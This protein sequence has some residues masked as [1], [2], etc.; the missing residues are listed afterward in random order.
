MVEESDT[1]TLLS[2]NLHRA[3]CWIP[4]QELLMGLAAFMIELWGE[5]GLRPLKNESNAKSLR[6][7]DKTHCNLVMRNMALKALE[8]QLMHRI[9]G[10][11]KNESVDPTNRHAFDTFDAE[12][13]C[14]L[15]GRGRLL[16]MS[17]EKEKNLSHAMVTAFRTEL[18]ADARDG[19]L[20]NGWKL[21]DLDVAEVDTGAM[22]I[23]I[24]DRVFIHR[25]Q[26]VHSKLYKRNIS[27]E[28]YLLQVRFVEDGG[29]KKYVGEAAMYARLV[30][31]D[32]EGP[33][34][35]ALCNFYPYLTPLVV[36]VEVEG[37]VEKKTSAAIREE[38]LGR[39]EEI[40]RAVHKGVNH[41]WSEDFVYPIRLERSRHK[42]NALCRR[43]RRF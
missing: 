16:V 32:K 29:E 12:Q 26:T 23:C 20:E 9:V 19:D 30:R 5:R 17:N 10:K 43:R 25:T 7:V 36:G 34:R 41:K 35:I 13:E 24:H 38:K 14:G 3:N 31:G 8:A 15:Q 21:S 33:L 37:G 2:G 1:W 4:D 39:K 18:E 40:L 11:R 22:C 28:S 42:I 6:D 27:R